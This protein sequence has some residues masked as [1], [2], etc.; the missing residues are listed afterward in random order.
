MSFKA[1][2]NVLLR[3]MFEACEPILM[4]VTVSREERSLCYPTVMMVT[5]QLSNCASVQFVCCQAVAFSLL[6]NSFMLSGLP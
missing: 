1:Q 5:R 2:E 6:S 4:C 3:E